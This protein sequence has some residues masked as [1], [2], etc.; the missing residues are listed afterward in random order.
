MIRTRA[1]E[2]VRTARAAPGRVHARRDKRETILEC[3]MP[4]FLKHGYEGTSMSMISAATGGSKATLYAYFPAKE[5]LFTALMLFAWNRQGLEPQSPM[6]AATAE[7]ARGWLTNWV[8]EY[9]RHLHDEAVLALHRLLIAEAGRFPHLAREAYA[10]GPVASLRQLSNDLSLL[11]RKGFVQAADF[12]EAARVLRAL[13]KA[14]SF[15]TRL[16]TLSSPP[17]SVDMQ[18]EAQLVVDHF[19]AIYGLA[20]TR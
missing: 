4:L 20:G 18:A 14:G 17:S 5:A 16:W 13:A 8:G 19:L 15:D 3:A 2:S 12:N 11:A 10:A 7:H 6:S 1:N 9:L